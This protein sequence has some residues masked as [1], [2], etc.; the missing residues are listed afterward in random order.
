VETAHS[1]PGNNLIVE[2]NG[3]PIRAKVAQT[4]YFD[5]ENARIRSEPAEDGRRSE[6]APRLVATTDSG[7]NVP[8][9][10]YTNGGPGS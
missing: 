8:A 5:P 2:V 10:Q 7:S 4:P 3:R 1:W 9:R 6:P